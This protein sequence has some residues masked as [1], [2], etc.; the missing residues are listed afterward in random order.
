MVGYGN[1]MVACL[2]IMWCKGNVCLCDGVVLV[3][4]RIV[5]SSYSVAH[6]GVVMA[7]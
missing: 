6:C 4:W 1:G 5:R 3:K 2:E 7:K